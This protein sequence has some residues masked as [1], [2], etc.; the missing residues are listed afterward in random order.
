MFKRVIFTVLAVLSLLA[1]V[2][3]T[4]TGSAAF[5]P[6]K[7]TCSAGGGVTNSDA[8]GASKK[9]PISGPNGILMKASLVLAT[10]GGVAAV[11]IIIVAGF[12]YVSSNGD[13][14]KAANARSAIIGAV[15]GLVVIAAA[16]SIVIFFVRHL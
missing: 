5:D 12:S 2:A 1:P 11:I 7:G 14:S 4:A 6:L 3:M 16:E 9:D 13:P 10:I 15:I 8:C